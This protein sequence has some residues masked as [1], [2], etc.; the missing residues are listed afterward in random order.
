MQVGFGDEASDTIQSNCFYA[1][2]GLVDTLQLSL[3][4]I[5]NVRTPGAFN[6]F[7][8]VAYDP[9]HMLGDMSVSYQ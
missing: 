6:W 8:V 9:I 2:Y 4:D 7:N 3:Y 1:M 5:Q